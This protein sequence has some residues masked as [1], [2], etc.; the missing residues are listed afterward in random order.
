VNSSGVW[1]RDVA[2]A[3]LQNLTANALV[4]A[5]ASLMHAIRA[6][7][8]PEDE[9]GAETSSLV[10]VHQNKIK[11]CPSELLPTPCSAA[12]AMCAVEQN[13]NQRLLLQVCQSVR[14]GTAVR[15]ASYAL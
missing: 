6:N 14:G 1:Y 9:K 4:Q 7:L 8:D 12:L 2:I 11:K 10:V 13:S 3:V 15:D 5:R